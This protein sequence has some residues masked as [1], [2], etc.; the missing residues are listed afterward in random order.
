MNEVGSP[1][2]SGVGACHDRMIIKTY[3][4]LRRKVGFFAERK[5]PLMVIEG[6]PGIGKTH[7]AAKACA[8]QER[9]ILR[10]HATPAAIIKRLYEN[11]NCIIIIDDIDGFMSNP[12]VKSLMKML[13]ELEEEKTIYWDSTASV[14]AGMVTPFDGRWETIVCC[15]RMGSLDMDLQAVL[16]RGIVIRFEPSNAE[17]LEELQSWFADKEILGEMRQ[18]KN[19][20]TRFDFRMALLAKCLKDAGD[21][22]KQ[23]LQEEMEISEKLVLMRE[24]QARECRC[25]MDRVK[26]WPGSRQDYYNWKKGY[27]EV[28]GWMSQ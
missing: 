24:L 23:Y 3:D 19:A 22:W 18:W 1:H 21:D 10:A 4:G 28:T 27:E 26:A 14:F 6:V 5:I 12:S 2:P 11:R 16:N 8:G 15:N 20:A 9:V 7:N 25:E 17:I 13:C